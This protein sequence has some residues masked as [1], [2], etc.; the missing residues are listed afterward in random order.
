[1]L[2]SSLACCE[3][4]CSAMSICMLQPTPAFTDESCKDMTINMILALSMCPLTKS[5]IVTDSHAQQQGRALYVTDQQ[6]QK[7]QNHGLTH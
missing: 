3:P 5:V 4:Y 1:M 6:Q 7:E 2:F